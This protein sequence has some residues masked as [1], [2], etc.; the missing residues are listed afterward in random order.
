MTEYTY[1]REL[2]NGVYDVN[3]P[4]RLDVEGNQIYLVDE[5]LTALSK[6]A[7]MHCNGSD[8][9]LEFEDELTTQEKTTLDTVVADHKANT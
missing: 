4:D 2:V 9:H 3:N 1:T 5:I 6:K 7:N 8:M